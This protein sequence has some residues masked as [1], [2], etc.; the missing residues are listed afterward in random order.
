MLRSVCRATRGVLVSSVVASTMAVMIAA[1]SLAAQPQENASLPEAESST[2]TAAEAQ[3]K[4]AIQYELQ[5]QWQLA[6][7]AARQAV[8]LDP[9]QARYIDKEA[10]LAGFLLLDE[11][12]AGNRPR[13][14]AL[15]AELLALEATAFGQQVDAGT[16]LR[17]GQAHFL[18]GDLEGAEPLLM[19]A[20]GVGLLNTEA[21]VWLFALYEKTG[22]EKGMKT[23][24]KSPWVQWRHVNPVYQAIAE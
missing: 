19:R 6:L 24:E 2:E 13:A 5:R 8:A 10:R 14:E 4:L 21:K 12:A 7:E 23:L 17:F 20:S 9:S 15:A 11:L 1:P 3:F 16:W 18:L 22:N